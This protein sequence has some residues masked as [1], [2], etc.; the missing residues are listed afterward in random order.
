MLALL[1]AFS[2]ADGLNRPLFLVLMVLA[3]LGTVLTAAYLLVMVRRVVFGGVP[4][5]WRTVRFAD[6]TA[7]ELAAWTP[8]LA[9]MAVLGVYP[10]LVLGL[11]DG[12][13]RALFGG[14]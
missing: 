11:T 14:P 9:L 8:L 12:A 1:A 2:P 6:V 10:R 3:G 4:E 7:L 5:R 13:V